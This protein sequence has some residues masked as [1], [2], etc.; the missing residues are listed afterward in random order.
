MSAP[1]SA[2]S[3][4]STSWDVIVIGGGPAG[5]SAA[6]T[7]AGEGRRVLVLEKEKFPRFHIGESLLPYNRELFEQLGV[8][9][10]I[11]SAGFMRKRGAQ[12]IMGNGP[13]KVRMNFSRGSFTEFPE[14][15]HVER[16]RFD[17]I[18]LNHAREQGAEVREEALVLEHQV[19]E[20]QVTVRYRTADGV[21]HTA[22]AAFLMDASGLSNFTGNREKSRV[23]YEGHKKVAIFGHFAGVAMCTGDEYGDILIIR[24]ENSWFWMIPLDDNKTSVGLVMDRGDFKNVGLPPQ[25]IFDEAVRTTARV[26]ERFQNA[27]ALGS[28]HTATDFSYRN[29]KLVSPRVVR[30]GDASGFIDPI[31]SSGVLLAMASGRQGGQVVSQALAQG[32]APLT[33]GMRRYERDNRRRISIYWQFIEKFYTQPFARLFFQPQDR[34]R[35]PCAINAVLAGRTS[36]PLGVRFRLWFFFLLAK[37][38]ERFPLTDPIE[39]R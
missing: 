9:E 34:L 16:S 38:N 35:L 22:T 26:A 8:W 13:Q 39:V 18:L 29:D 1:I 2:L 11:Q 14:S 3:A 17:E 15:I 33:S 20:N 30:I 28:L 24:R 23:Y 5:S 6:I 21:E 31:F 7:L 4:D 25:E 37:I 36:L 12:F 19:G 32:A 27:K 10:K